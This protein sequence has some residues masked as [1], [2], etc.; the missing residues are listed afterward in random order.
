M[1][2]VRTIYCD[3]PNTIGGFTILVDDFFTIVLNQNL[4]HEKNLESYMH[5]L[6]HIKNGDFDKKVSAG[7]IEI[8]AHAH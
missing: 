3:M 6:E 7:L 2:N 4:S 5:E 8:M 1:E